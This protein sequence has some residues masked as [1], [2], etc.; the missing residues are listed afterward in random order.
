M[1]NARITFEV[2]G[3]VYSLYFGMVATQII[4]EKSVKTVKNS[5]VEK[6]DNIKA[7][8][9]IIYGGLCNDADSRD[10]ERPEFTEAYQIADSIVGNDELTTRIYSTWE[11]SKP[12]TELLAK[13]GIDKK[14]EEIKPIKKTGTQSK[15]LPSGN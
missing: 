13:L 8:A 14:K 9:Y 6:V 2:E 7:F 11:N 1:S 4:S 15:P 12:Y 5:K 3:N 10:I